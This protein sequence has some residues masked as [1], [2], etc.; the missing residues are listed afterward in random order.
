MGDSVA[1]S[2]ENIFYH[3]QEMVV[4]LSPLLLSFSFS[5]ILDFKT[6]HIDVPDYNKLGAQDVLLL[7]YELCRHRSIKEDGTRQ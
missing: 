3:S 5:H 2:F 4:L 6:E 7:I 1:A